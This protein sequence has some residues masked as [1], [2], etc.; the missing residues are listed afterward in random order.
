MNFRET[1]PRQ[2]G[3]PDHLYEKDDVDF[4]RNLRVTKETFNKLLQVVQERTS[5]IH[6][7]GHPPV[8]SKVRLEIGLWYLGNKATYRE[9]AELFG[10][11]ESC[12]FTCVQ[13]V[14]EILCDLSKDYIKWPTFSEA[15]EQG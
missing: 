4:F 2:Q 10:V 1:H 3:F 5:H 14:I 9:I 8:S 13:S 15:V 7:G 11:S 6:H 12:A